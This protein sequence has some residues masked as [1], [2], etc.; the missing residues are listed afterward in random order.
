MQSVVIIQLIIII[1]YVFHK[2]SY[3]LAA[4]KLLSSQGKLT[5]EN[6]LTFFKPRQI[7]TAADY[8]SDDIVWALTEPMQRPIVATL[9]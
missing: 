7:T 9:L 4:V 3:D 5:L 2:T 8:S 1:F 6:A